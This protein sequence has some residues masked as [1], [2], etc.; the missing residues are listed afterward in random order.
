[1]FVS[2]MANT[3]VCLRLDATLEAP[4]YFVV[5][6]S[7][8][9][10]AVSALL[11]FLHLSFQSRLL[12]GLQAQPA[13]APVHDES[14]RKAGGAQTRAIHAILCQR[15]QVGQ[16]KGGSGEAERREGKSDPSGS[17]RAV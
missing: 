2:D 1:M 3:I 4:K 13:L 11:L 12:Q 16:L 10:S 5:Y 8:Q 7:L 6:P 14:V 17:I 9:S 15:E